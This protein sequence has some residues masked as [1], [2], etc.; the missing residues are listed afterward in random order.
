MKVA[1]SEVD[2]KDEDK[3]KQALLKKALGYQASD[4]VEEYSIDDTGKPVLSKKKITKKHYGADI[5]AVKVL[6][7]RFYKTYDQQVLGM[8]DEAL[9]E[10]RLALLQQMQ[11]GDKSGD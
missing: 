3:I 2:V 11:K 10:E 5:S 4:V 1:K 7:E 9:A 6:L 8:S